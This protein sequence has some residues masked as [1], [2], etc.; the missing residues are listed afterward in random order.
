MNFIGI[1]PGLKGAI[2]VLDSSGKIIQMLDMPVNQR[3]KK[4]NYKAPHVRP[5]HGVFHLKR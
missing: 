4:F 5:A 3:T 1:D 2:A